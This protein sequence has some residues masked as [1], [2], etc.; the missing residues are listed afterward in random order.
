[1]ANRTRHDDTTTPGIV[2][3]LIGAGLAFLL[4]PDHGKRRRAMALDR[5][6]ALVRQI[7]RRLGRVMRYVGSEAY[8]MKQ[9]AIHRGPWSETTQRREELTQV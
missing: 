4:D 8:G 1:M 2:F 6:T 5:S 3:V 7:G 9:K